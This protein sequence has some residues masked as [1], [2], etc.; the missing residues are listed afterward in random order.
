MHIYQEV[1]RRALPQECIEACSAPGSIDA[2]ITYWTLRLN[3]TVDRECAIRALR[4]TDGW[5]QEEL[6]A[7]T[8]L[9]L[10]QRVLWLAAGYFDE[11]GQD[12]DCFFLEG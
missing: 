11:N 5:D 12:V 3:L 8:D 7:S 6:N 10:A 2:A 4:S 9:Q 1:H